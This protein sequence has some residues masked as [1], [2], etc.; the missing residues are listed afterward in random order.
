MARMDITNSWVEGYVA[1][2]HESPLYDGNPKL[3]WADRVRALPVTIDGGFERIE[4][5][6]WLS[7]R[8]GIIDSFRTDW[9][10]NPSDDTCLTWMDLIAL[11][12][13][14]TH[15]MPFCDIPEAIQLANTAQ[16][17]QACKILARLAVAYIENYEEPNDD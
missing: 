17:L 5:A 15:D 7:K 6:G 12:E 2:I 3:T 14:H 13:T 10:L 16:R 1:A 9:D 8:N 4:F 11:A